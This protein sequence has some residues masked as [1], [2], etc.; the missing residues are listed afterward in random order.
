MDLKTKEKKIS[1]TNASMAIGILR[2]QGSNLKYTQTDG[3]G[4]KEGAG[5]K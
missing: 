3:C 1:F 5:H 2:I 4:I